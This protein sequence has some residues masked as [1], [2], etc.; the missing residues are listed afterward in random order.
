MFLGL[1]TEPPF[2]YNSERPMYR[3]SFAE[4]QVVAFPGNFWWLTSLLSN[5]KYFHTEKGF[6][7]ILGDET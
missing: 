5:N 4:V 6:I 1:A 7:I 2:S 3:L